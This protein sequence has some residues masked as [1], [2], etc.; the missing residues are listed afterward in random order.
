MSTINLGN[1]VTFEGTAK[2]CAAF[3]KENALPAVPTSVA[4]TPA[5]VVAVDTGPRKY[6]IIGWDKTANGIIITLDAYPSRMV[7]YA[8]MGVGVVW[9]GEHGK[10][11]YK[12]SVDTNRKDVEQAIANGSK[13]A[14]EF[15]TTH[16]RG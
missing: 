6:N 7:Q 8:M 12:C 3:L 15:A 2:E 9:T 4:P 16:P 11:R 14:H 1:G 10:L 13:R 5:E